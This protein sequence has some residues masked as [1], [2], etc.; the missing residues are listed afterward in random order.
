MRRPLSV[1]LAALV[2]GLLPPRPAARADDDELPP[3]ERK[4]GDL[5]L[6]DTL[7]DIQRIYVPSREWPSYVE[8][9]HGVT[10]IKIERPDLKSPAQDVDVMWLGLK[11]D[12]LVELQLIYDARYTKE[13]S[14]NSLVR[15]LSLVY[16][17]PDSENGRYWWTDGRTVLRVFYAEVPV[18]RGGEKGSEL[19]TSLQV[20]ETWLF[21]K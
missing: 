9:K 20:A 7:E 18:R 12:R 6:G 17:E 16:G 14:V 10:R 3:V 4:L 21:N 15:E 5:Y 8:P 19:R 11:H 2:L 13:H 1:L